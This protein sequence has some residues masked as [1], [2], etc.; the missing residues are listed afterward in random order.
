MTQNSFAEIKKHV[1]KM[2]E[3]GLSE[4]LSYHNVAH[5][6]YVLEQVDIISLH[7]KIAESDLKLLKIAAL[8]HD[9]GF[10]NKYENHEAESCRIAKDQ[11]PEFGFGA[12]QIEI[13]CGMIMATKIPQNPHNQ[14][15]QVIADA[16]LEYLGTH[17]YE[18]IAASLFK[19]MKHRN[20]ALTEKEWIDIQIR[21]LE[22]HSYFT[23]YCK[24][25]REAHKQQNLKELKVLNYNK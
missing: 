5:T 10:M 1:V 4:K 7:E 12:K 20:P 6:L 13:I 15:E 17:N 11:L 9:S 3:R 2:L 21:F 22:Y 23:E 25:N 16:D 8:Y 14:L 19:E 18:A 24:K